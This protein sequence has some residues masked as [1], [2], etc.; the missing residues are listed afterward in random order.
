MAEPYESGV[1]AGSNPFTP[2][3]RAMISELVRAGVAT[4]RTAASGSGAG[5]VVPAAAGGPASTHPSSS[6]KYSYL[7]RVSAGCIT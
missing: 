6:G 1:E 3:Q 5:A 7:L 4:G 2:E